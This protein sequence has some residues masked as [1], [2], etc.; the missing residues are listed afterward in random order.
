MTQFW[1]PIPL[2]S[3]KAWILY[4]P[5]GLISQKSFK[6]TTFTAFI[7]LKMWPLWLWKVILSLIIN[8]KYP[9]SWT[10]RLFFILSEKWRKLWPWQLFFDGLIYYLQ[11]KCAAHMWYIMDYRRTRAL[12]TCCFFTFAFLLFYGTCKN[13]AD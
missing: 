10:F 11:I 3:G 2:I 8:K 7:T 12:C 4:T 13:T 5:C 1:S 6:I 9:P